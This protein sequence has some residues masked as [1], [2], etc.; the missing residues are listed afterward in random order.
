MKEEDSVNQIQIAPSI[1]EKK[2]HT[3]HYFKGKSACSLKYTVLS[4]KTNGMYTCNIYEQC[5][6]NMQTHAHTNTP[7]FIHSIKDN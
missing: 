2:N 6:I 3:F 1:K 4:E 5:G 7:V